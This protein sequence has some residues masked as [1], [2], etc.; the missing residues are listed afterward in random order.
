VMTF[1]FWH[2]YEKM[3][4]MCGGNLFYVWIDYDTEYVSFKCKECGAVSRQTMLRGFQQ[5]RG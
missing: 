1:P 3:C 5:N 4:H 2:N